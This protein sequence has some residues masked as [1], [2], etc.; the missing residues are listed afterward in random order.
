[1]IMLTNQLSNRHCGVG[2]RAPHYA[3]I[4]Q[5][6]PTLGL[7]EIHSENFFD[8]GGLNRAYLEVLRTDYA[9]SAH[10]VGLSL[11]GTDA[12]DVEHLTKLKALV[13]WLE[14]ALVSEHL[15]WVGVD[16]RFSNDLL[17]LPY[18]EG[19]IAH[20]VD[21]INAVQD[22]LARPILIENLSSYVA[23]DASTMPEWEFVNT[24]AARS[25]CKILLDIN[26]IFV[27]AKNHQYAGEAYISAISSDYVGQM[28]LAGH[29]VTESILIDTH[30]A[31]VCEAVWQLFASAVRRFGA[32][33]TIVEWDSEI[34]EWSV[35]Q[36][37]VLR[38]TQIMQDAAR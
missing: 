9:V 26:N 31:P 24:V 32:R 18:T 13:D 36:A 38:A 21:R 10:G 19:V 5:T 37:E 4:L 3:E 20:V 23:F 33:P 2:L 28:H 1:M 25:G 16:G 7:L 12:L 29:T 6:K 14:P 30:S 17:P 22:Y 15:C 34:P 35:L 27:S 8:T 11:G